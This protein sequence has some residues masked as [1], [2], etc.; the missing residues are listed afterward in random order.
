MGYIKTEIPN[1]NI[2]YIAINVPIGCVEN[3]K[4]VLGDNVVLDYTKDVIGILQKMF[5]LGENILPINF[6]I[7]KTHSDRYV[8]LE[9][10]GESQI[11]L[12]FKEDDQVPTDTK[13]ILQCVEYNKHLLRPCE[14]LIIETTHNNVT[15]IAK[16]GRID[17]LE[18]HMASG[19]FKLFSNCKIGE[20]FIL[21]NHENSKIY[22][23]YPNTLY[24]DVNL[25]F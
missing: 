5:G 1:K 19:R 2:K 6:T 4:L 8:I 17:K 7:N 9:T 14:H 10:R 23:L 11:Q 16:N 24:F 13:Q 22:A 3:F 20:D 15:L 25:H 12:G 21:T 18:S